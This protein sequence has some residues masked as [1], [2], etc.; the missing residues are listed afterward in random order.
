MAD[1]KHLPDGNFIN[2]EEVEYIKVEDGQITL[3]TQ[4]NTYHAELDAEWR[5]ILKELSA[6]KND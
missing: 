5:E 4:M 3:E 2:L 6:G 1:W